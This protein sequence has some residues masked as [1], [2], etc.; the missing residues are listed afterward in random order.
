MG[1]Y[2]RVKAGTKAAAVA[3]AALSNAPP[4]NDL[5]RGYAH[6]Q[7]Y[8]EVLNGL[9]PKTNM[10]RKSAGAPNALAGR[11]TMKRR[12]SKLIKPRKVKKVRVP[13]RLKKQIKQVLTAKM[14]YGSYKVCKMGTIGIAS[15]GSTN[16]VDPVKDVLGMTAQLMSYHPKSSAGTTY[17]RSL[18]F[19]PLSQI[20]S[21]DPA[22]PGNYA[23][24]SPWVFFHPLKYL[25]AAS[26]L[27]NNKAIAADWGGRTGN[28]ETRVNTSTGAGSSSKTD[29]VKLNVV[30]SFVQFELK[31]NSKR[32]VTIVAYHI[33]SKNKLQRQTAITAWLDAFTEDSTTNGPMKYIASSGGLTDPL[34]GPGDSVAFNQNYKYETVKII[35]KPGETCTHSLKGLR[36]AVIDYGKMYQDNLDLEDYITKD[37]VQVVFAVIPDMQVVTSSSA[38]TGAFIYAPDATGNV[39]ADP[40]SIKWTEYYKL[41]CPETAGFIQ[42]AV[43][44]GSGQP[45]NLKRFCKA[46]ANFATYNVTEPVAYTGADEE[47]PA[48]DQAA[49]IR[50]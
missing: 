37:C 19:C 1:V 28:I 36:N 15:L 34:M 16:P 30:N 39:L 40:I 2:D 27:W 42:K 45:L 10:K 9:L 29:G 50:Y 44:A 43:S 3:L 25:D 8:Q 46:F 23:T 49:G 20:T 38:S 4:P 47:Q 21:A 32:S 35:I 11:A 48:T 6:V 33:K 18:W 12:G 17:N 13:K 24:G 14:I 7:R 22:T 31:N 5:D 41:K 26:I